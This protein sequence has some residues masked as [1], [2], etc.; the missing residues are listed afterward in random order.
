MPKWKLRGWVDKWQLWDRKE[1]FHHRCLIWTWT[2]ISQ[3]CRGIAQTGKHCLFTQAQFPPTIEKAVYEG[4][5]DDSAVTEHWFFQRAQV[6][7]PV[8]TWQL[9]VVC[10]SSSISSKSFGFSGHTHAYKYMQTKYTYIQINFLKR[11]TWLHT[12]IF[13]EMETQGSPA[14]LVNSRSMETT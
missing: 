9:T 13:P 3:S 14:S 2:A 5:R 10:K 4:W 11:R 1:V 6:Q 8:P 7:F 12:L